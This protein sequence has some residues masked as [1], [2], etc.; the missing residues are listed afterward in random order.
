MARVFA[1]DH[2]LDRRGIRQSWTGRMAY[3]LEAQTVE[4]GSFTPIHACAQMECNSHLLGAA[5]THQQAELQ[6]PEPAQEK[7]G[8]RTEHRQSKLRLQKSWKT[9]KRWSERF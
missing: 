9:Q 3:N 4:M 8:T 5:V 1:K 7:M 6:T 2:T